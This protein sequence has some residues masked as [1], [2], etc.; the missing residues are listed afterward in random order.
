[1]G[2]LRDLREVAVGR[3]VNIIEQAAVYPVIGGADGTLHPAHQREEQHLGG[4]ATV[5]EL[6]DEFALAGRDAGGHVVEV[7]GREQQE[8]LYSG[9]VVAREVVDDLVGSQRVTSQ[10]NVAVALPG[11]VVKVGLDV[12]VGQRETLVPR[13]DDFLA[14]RVGVH[15][16]NGSEGIVG[17]GVDEVDACGGERV[18]DVVVEGVRVEVL[19]EQ[20]GI[21]ERPWMPVM[22]ISTV[23][24]PPS[25]ANS[26][27][28]SS[29]PRFVSIF[30]SFIS[31]A[32]MRLSECKENPFSFLASL[33]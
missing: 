26:T 3:G 22:A 5:V 1:M 29:T 28:S 2:D 17:L 16:S 19:C 32:M 8:V 27:P 30:S 4:M 10:D 23:S 9:C 21:A 13:A 12:L 25:A 24:A 14:T 18:A 31:G 33:R 6:A 15:G 11:G 20:S 7:G